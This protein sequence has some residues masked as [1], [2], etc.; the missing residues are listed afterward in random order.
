MRRKPTAPLPSERDE[1]DDAAARG[2]GGRERRS[3]A[4]RSRYGEPPGG[5]DGR[6]PDLA[7]GGRGDD[8]RGDDQVRGGRLGE[9]LR[10]GAR[11]GALRLRGGVRCAP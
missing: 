4:G 1:G 2:G 5:L 7:R 11:G 9:R 10:R 3:L 6:Q 8:R